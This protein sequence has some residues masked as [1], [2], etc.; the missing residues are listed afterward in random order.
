MALRRYKGDASKGDDLTVVV[1]SNATPVTA[2][3]APS[4][5][6]M[7]QAADAG[8]DALRKQIEALQAAKLA[9]MPPINGPPVLQQATADGLL[10]DP[11][12]AHALHRH[13]DPHAR[14]RD[15]WAKDFLERHPH[16]KRSRHLAHLFDAAHEAALASG[17]ED[18]S[19]E[20]FHDL[21]RRF[22]ALFSP[23]RQKPER[24]AEAA[25]SEDQRH[26]AMVSAPPSRGAHS[27]SGDII[28]AKITLTAEQVDHAR[29]AGI[30]PATYAVNLVKMRQ[31]KARGLLDDGQR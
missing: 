11:H 28:P 13:P 18:A 14:R 1:P 25:E 4:A 9:T 5:P 15:Q 20:Y 8:V 21:E 17:H 31:M 24:K 30:D 2:Q 6:P 12:H 10:Q 23:H 26:A 16:A 19:D 29:A 3:V 22:D 7:P 27:Y